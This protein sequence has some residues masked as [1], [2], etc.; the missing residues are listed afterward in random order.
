MIPFVVGGT[1]DNPQIELLHWNYYP[2][3]NPGN[4]KLSKNLGYVSSHFA[5]SIDT[6]QTKGVSK[7]PLLVTSPNSRIISTPALISLNE[8]KNVP[9]DEKFRQNGIPVAMLL[10][11]NF[12]SLY[13]NRISQSQRDTLAQYGVLF[14]NESVDNKI[15]VVADGDIVFNDYIP[16]EQQGQPPVPLP[17]GWNKYTYREYTK[18]TEEGKYFV[19]VANQEFLLNCVEYLVNNP[20]IAQTRNKEIVLRLLDSKKVKMQMTTWQLINI[21]VPVLLT[22]LLGVFY[23]QVRKNKYAR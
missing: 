3:L 21:V 4:N 17:M 19:P 18:Q 7:I 1:Q 6:I 20:A 2:L 23:Q 16:A 11:G 14:S 13:K 9:E 15:I 12:S 10:E 8:N 5:N 22:L